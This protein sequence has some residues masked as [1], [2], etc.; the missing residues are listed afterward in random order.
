MR[1]DGKVLE[2]KRA[3]TSLDEARLALVKGGLKSERVQ[4]DV[5]GGG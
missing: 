5:S 1:V 3:L 4:G 2:A